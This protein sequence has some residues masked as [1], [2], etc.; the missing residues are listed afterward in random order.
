MVNYR[1]PVEFITLRHYHTFVLFQRKSFHSSRHLTWKA[2]NFCVC[3]FFSLSSGCVIH[4]WI[5]HSEMQMNFFSF[6]F[7]FFSFIPM[8]F[9][10]AFQINQSFHILILFVPGLCFFCFILKDNKFHLSWSEWSFVYLSRIYMH[11]PPSIESVRCALWRK[12]GKI[13]I[14]MSIK[15]EYAVCVCVRVSRT[16]F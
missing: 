5:Y 4:I 10:H 8:S 14:Y 15:L 13:Y 9:M 12:R 7:F 1:K 6:F 11:K 16:Q 2:L 3:F